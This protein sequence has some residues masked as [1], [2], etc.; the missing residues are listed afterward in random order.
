MSCM[1]CPRCGCPE[2]CG[3]D[4]HDGKRPLILYVLGM[5]MIIPFIDRVD[6]KETSPQLDGGAALSAVLFWPLAAILGIVFLIC[7]GLA[8]QPTREGSR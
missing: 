8:E 1:E 3:C 5:P 2:I 7:R 4:C 6:Q